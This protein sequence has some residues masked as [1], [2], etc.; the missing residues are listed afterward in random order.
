MI[1]IVARKTVE[2][3]AFMTIDKSML[4]I[5]YKNI[6]TD[7]NTHAYLTHNHTYSRTPKTY[8][9]KDKKYSCGEGN[10]Q[11]IFEVF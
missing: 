10:N 9:R 6:H 11:S 2:D 5:S 8:I 3:I 1:L 7:R 4:T